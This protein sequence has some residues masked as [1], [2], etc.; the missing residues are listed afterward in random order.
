MNNQRVKLADYQALAEFRYQIRRF[1]YFSEAAA[2]QAGIE[3]QHHQLML[4]IKGK[5]DQEQARIA[6]LAERLQIQHNSAVEL[7]DR[8]VKK[9]L[10]TR[11]RGEHD[12]REVYVQLTPR[13]E[14]ILD[15]LT[16]HTRAELRSAGPALVSTL[17]KLTRPGKLGRRQRRRPRTPAAGRS[18]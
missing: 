17:R 3:P 18:K 5:A 7:V 14:R 10:I 12:R 1:L 9:G 13:G 4:A 8:L 6:Y 15:E 16:R 11:T 2:R